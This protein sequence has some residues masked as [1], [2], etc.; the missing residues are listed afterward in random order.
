[1]EVDTTCVMTVLHNTIAL[2]MLW[3]LCLLLVFNFRDPCQHAYLVNECAVYV[4]HN[5]GCFT[6]C[7]TA[8]VCLYYM[9]YVRISTSYVTFEIN[10]F[11][12]NSFI[13]CIM[14]EDWCGCC[15]LFGWM[16]I[17]QQVRQHCKAQLL[18]HLLMNHLHRGC[19]WCTTHPILV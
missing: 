17:L 1:M 7:I 19:A 14:W 5:K 11:N 6:T 15:S 8:V 16:E 10:M 3:S 9:F 4:I 2:I 12:R 18:V 13:K